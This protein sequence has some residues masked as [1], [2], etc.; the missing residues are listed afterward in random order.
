MPLDPLH[1]RQ[2]AIRQNCTTGVAL[3]AP[4]G[5]RDLVDHLLELRDLEVDV[6]VRDLAIYEQIAE[7]FAEPLAAAGVSPF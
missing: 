7:Q 4:R 5:R 6:A 2:H 1:R 3:R